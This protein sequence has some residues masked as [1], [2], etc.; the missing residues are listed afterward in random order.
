MKYKLDEIMGRGNMFWIGIYRE[1][2]FDFLFFYLNIKGYR[3][4]IIYLN[5]MKEIKFR[6]Y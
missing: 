6:L 4:F 2:W 3:I 1:M 5:Y